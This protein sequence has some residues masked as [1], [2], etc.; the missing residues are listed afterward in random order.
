MHPM[1]QHKLPTNC[2]EV[3]WGHMVAMHTIGE[4]APLPFL[5]ECIANL[6]LMVKSHV[7]AGDKVAHNIFLNVFQELSSRIKV[8]VQILM[9]DH[10]L[11]HL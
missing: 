3:V 6:V 4:V 1:R 9:M 7:G 2:F 8:V 11:F 5:V 10:G